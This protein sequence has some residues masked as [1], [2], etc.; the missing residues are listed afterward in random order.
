MPDLKLILG[1]AKLTALVQIIQSTLELADLW[2]LEKAD[3]A[4]IVAA[5]YLN[6]ENVSKKDAALKL[7]TWMSKA[8]SDPLHLK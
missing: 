6:K 3:I 7:N 8:I 4:L 1:A 5:R 2:D